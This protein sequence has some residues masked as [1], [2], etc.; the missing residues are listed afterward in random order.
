MSIPPLYD[1]FLIREPLRDDPFAVTHNP[2][3][4]PTLIE[5]YSKSISHFTERNRVRAV[6]RLQY[7]LALLYIREQK[8][9]KALHLLLVVYEGSSWRREGWWD[10]LGLLREQVSYV[11]RVCG[12]PEAVLRA[13]WEGMCDCECVNDMGIVEDGKEGWF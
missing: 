4:I 2:S 5:V 6:E 13:E 8:W 1:T 7:E 11:G 12:D 10:L 3:D 9:K